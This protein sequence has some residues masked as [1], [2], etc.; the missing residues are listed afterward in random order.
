MANN[1]RPSLPAN[2]NAPA[3]A[4]N[5]YI[6]PTNLYAFPPNIDANY[7]PPGEYLPPSYPPEPPRQSPVY[8]GPVNPPSN[9]ANDDSDGMAM[10]GDGMADPNADANNDASAQNDDANA[11]D[12]NPSLMSTGSIENDAPQLSFRPTPLP[13]SDDPQ[14]DHFHGHDHP[15]FHDYGPSRPSDLPF[16]FDPNVLKDDH[17]PFH[18]DIIFDHDPHHD[19][20]HDPHHDFLDFHHHHPP[21]RP[22]PPPPTTPPPPPPPPEEPPEE[23]EQPRVKKYSYFYLSR[24]LW[25]IPLYFTVY[26]VFYVTWLILQSIGRHKVRCIVLLFVFMHDKRSSSIST[27]PHHH[28]LLF[29][30]STTTN[31]L[32]YPITW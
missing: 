1:D 13:P 15:P 28:F 18:S 7:P 10:N 20:F 9:T 25:Y 2:D 22:P 12:G 24:S 30:P 32:T 31:R 6:P 16:P 21:P 27:Y 29:S 19:H 3:P 8:Q 4:P 5:T 23:P 26:F 14:H 17:H 11:D